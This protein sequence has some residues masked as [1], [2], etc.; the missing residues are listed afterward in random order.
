MDK[1]QELERLRRELEQMEL[2]A[3][4]AELSASMA[5]DEVLETLT[6]SGNASRL[7]R[8]IDGQAVFVP[9]LGEWARWDNEKWRADDRGFMTR[10]VKNV[11]VEL[12]AAQKQIEEDARNISDSDERKEVFKKAGLVGAWA[13]RTQMAATISNTIRLASCEEGISVRYK[14]FDSKGQFFGVKNG[15]VDLRTGVLVQGQPKYLMML[16]SNVEYNPEAECPNWER[17]LREVTNDD[18]GKM[19]LLQQIAGSALVGNTKEKMFIFSGAGSNGKSTFINMLSRVLG[20]TDNGGYSAIAKPEVFIGGTANPEYFIAPLKG[21]R[22]I[23]MSETTES[24]V[25]NDVIV[26]QCVDS[27]EGVVGRKVGQ[28]PFSFTIKG[29]LLMLTNH[30]PKVITTDNGTWRRLCLVKWDRV[31]SEEEKDRTLKDRLNAE[32]EGILMWAVVGAI[33]YFRQGQ[34]FVIPENVAADTVEWRQGEDKL[35]S[36]MADELIQGNGKVKLTTFMERYTEWCDRKNQYAGSEKEV[37][38]SLT[39]RG[40]EVRPLGHGATNHI[41]GWM[42]RDRDAEGMTHIEDEL[43]RLRGQKKKE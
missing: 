31:F 18:A 21:A 9:E 8:I 22:L 5:H 23:F 11:V 19:D 3:A 1:R 29:T 40:I 33:K 32:L 30:I 25:L 13:K 4:E 43:A 17:F 26:K 37:K 36:F 15:I 14:D 38:K 34:K 27:E 41:V 20:S 6:D 39:Q 24:G 42:F 12:K 28:E 7:V 16:S 10:M 35:G 2:A